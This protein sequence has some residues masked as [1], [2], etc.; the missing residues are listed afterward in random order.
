MPG[1]RLGG[2]GGR[3]A[4]PGQSG[5][6]SLHRLYYPRPLGWTAGHAGRVPD[7]WLAQLDHPGRLTLPGRGLARAGARVGGHGGPR[8]LGSDL[9]SHCA[10]STTKTCSP[11]QRGCLNG[12]ENSNKRK[13]CNEILTVTFSDTRRGESRRT[14]RSSS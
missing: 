11:C 2:R 7:L 14:C 4:A 6:G 1:A 10:L 8:P 3:G 13:I 5:V 12:L 9:R